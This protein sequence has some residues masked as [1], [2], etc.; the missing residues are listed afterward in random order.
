VS[1]TRG[2]FSRLRVLWDAVVHVWLITHSRGAYCASVII[3]LLNLPLNLSPDS[4]ARAAGHTSLFGGL[5]EWISRCKLWLSLLLVASSSLT[6]D[7][8]RPNVRRG[9]LGQPGY[10]GP[11]GLRILCTGV[12][13]HH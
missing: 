8:K 13:I 5:A 9:H 4:P 7:A 12:S 2:G 3:S 6:H 10:R 1:F 11:W